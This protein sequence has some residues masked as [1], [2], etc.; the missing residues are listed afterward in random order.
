MAVMKK[1]M[2]GASNEVLQDTYEYTRAKT[3]D[4]PAPS[5]E[6]IKSALD[7]LSYQYPQAKQTDP[8]LLID[9]S[10]VKRIEQSGFIRALSKKAS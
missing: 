10:F 4:V 1:Y 5:L 3:E 6:V 9:S 2:R 8:N 7:I